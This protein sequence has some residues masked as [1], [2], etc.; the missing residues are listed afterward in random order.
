MLM[1]SPL[2][3]DRR[4]PPGFVRPC[5]PTT[6][7]TVPSGHEWIHELKHDGFRLMV[8]KDDDRVRVWS[9]NGRDWSLNFLAITAAGRALPSPRV[10]IDGEA[11]AHCEEGLPHFYRLLGY[12]GQAT[13]CLYAFDL[14]HI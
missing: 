9:R 2:A 12:E 3:R 11:M 7:D 4:A 10:M 8:L 5:Q 1:R 6:S 13:A 14:L